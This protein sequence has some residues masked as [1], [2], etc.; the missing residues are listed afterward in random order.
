MKM[1]HLQE[2]SLLPL[3]CCMPELSV[4]LALFFFFLLVLKCESVEIYVSQFSLELSTKFSLLGLFL[5]ASVTICFSCHCPVTGQSIALALM[6]L[7]PKSVCWKMLK[8]S[9]THFVDGFSPFLPPPYGCVCCF[10]CLV[11][12]YLI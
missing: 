1:R 9:K 12:V 6:Q 11:F 8:T 5:L 7:H 2:D 10:S 3:K 4:C